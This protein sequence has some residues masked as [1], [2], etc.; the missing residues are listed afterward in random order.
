MS[1][2]NHPNIHAVGLAM[3]ML[4]SI[5]KNLRGHADE[6]IKDMGDVISLL[7]GDIEEFIIGISTKLDKNY[8]KLDLNRNWDNK[9]EKVDKVEVDAVIKN[10]SGFIMHLK[11]KNTGS[12]CGGSGEWATN[13]PKNITTDSTSVTCKTCRK[14]V[15]WKLKEIK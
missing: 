1:T 15:A 4:E 8:K 10:R 9:E 3:D 5:R 2:R 7:R 6:R 14:S 13:Y 12:E 11:G